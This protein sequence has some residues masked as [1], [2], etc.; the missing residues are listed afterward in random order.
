MT[1][2]K[3]W[4]KIIVLNIV[5]TSCFIMAGFGLNNSRQ[6]EQSPVSFYETMLLSG[7]EAFFSGEY[8]KAIKEL[9]IA[10]FGLFHRKYLAAKA[11]I[12]ISLSYSHL[13]DRDNAGGFLKEAASLV[14]E[15]ELRAI[16]LYIDDSDSEVLESLIQ[17]F[18]V[19]SDV[20]ELPELEEDPLPVEKSQK[21]NLKVEVPP[22]P[23]K[24]EQDKKEQ[25]KIEQEKIEQAKIEQAK[26]VMPLS[27]DE[28]IAQLVEQR[29]KQQSE[30]L[31]EK[32]EVPVKKEPAKKTAEKIQE[33]D[34]Q[35]EGLEE[36]FI[37]EGPVQEQV[38]SE[39]RIQKGTSSIDIG[40]LFHPYTQHQVFEI[41][42]TPPKR[43]VIDIHN[44]TG[45]KAGRSIA[46]ND[47][48]ITSIRTG[49][50][51]DNIARVVFDAEEDLPSYRIEKT[52]GG[53]RVVIEKSAR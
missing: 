20:T 18:D 50:F 6:E 28:R 13:E 43:I 44:I 23:E 37:T 41:I 34:T 9:E 1:G 29:K 2:K 17:D 4:G 22:I 24:I 39:I 21:E 45:I 53:L 36:L 32:S 33:K 51:K 48:G 16:E 30:Q 12:L 49:M 7:E 38:L 47:F 27:V 5:L 14:N 31:K 52:E 42:D 15:Q 35:I 3:V 40:I 10:A 11:Y 25:D 46:I 26:K 8:I 19:F